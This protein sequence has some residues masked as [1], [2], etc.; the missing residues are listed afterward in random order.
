MA[1]AIEGTRQTVAALAQR[2]PTQIRLAAYPNAGLPKLDRKTRETYYLQG[3]QDMVGQL[4]ELRD[5]GAWLVGGCCGTG[6]DHIRAFRSG[7]DEAA[8]N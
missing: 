6:P 8:S 2:G 5:S 3:P 4:T 7:L 1:Y